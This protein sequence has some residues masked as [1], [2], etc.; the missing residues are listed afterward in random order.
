MKEVRQISVRHQYELSQEM[1]LSTHKCLVPNELMRRDTRVTT[2]GTNLYMCA[3]TCATP[4]RHA[5]VYTLYILS[6]LSVLSVFY[7]AYG[8]FG[9]R[10][11]LLV[12]VFDLSIV[13]TVNLWDR[14][15]STLKFMS[16]INWKSIEGPVPHTVV[17][18]IIMDPL[19]KEI[20]LLWR[21][22]NVRSAKECWSIPSGLHEI[23]EDQVTAF[24]REILEELAVVV[25]N[26]VEYLGMYENIGTEQDPY[27]WVISV[28][29]GLA[30][31]S[32]IT[33]REPDKHKIE[34]VSAASVLN[35]QAFLSRQWAPALGPWIAKNTPL[36]KMLVKHNS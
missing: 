6:V 24:K 11:L 4:T 30:D 32:P 14:H 33:N 5:C 29:F 28:F 1:D 12:S 16:K 27:H 7:I 23:G 31:F 20:C 13:A 17:S 26:K 2:S 35:G 18:G 3:T 22:A 9:L 15:H 25:S 36:I 8:C 19:T 34:L 21:T 10:Q